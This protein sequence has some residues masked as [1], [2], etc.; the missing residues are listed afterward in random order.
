MAQPSRFYGYVRVSRVQGREGDTFISPAVQEERIRAWARGRGVE[1]VEVVHELDRSG[2]DDTRPGF[3]R[4][5]AAVEDG[6]ADGIVVAKLDRFARSLLDALLAV[7][8][9]MQGGGHLASVAEGFDTSTTMGRA[10]VAMM[11]IWAEVELERI[12]E[13]WD[14]AKG[15]A[16][17]RGVHIS[18]HVPCGYSRDPQTRRLVAIPDAVPV[19]RELF[20]RRAAGERWVEL[21]DFMRASGLRTNTG[22][23]RWTHAA[24]RSLITNRVYLGEARHGEHVKAGAH[25]AM[26]TQAQFDAAQGEKAAPQ[27]VSSGYELSGLV[28]CAGC[29]NRSRGSLTTSH[30]K[31]KRSYT[32]RRYHAAG[33]CPATGN[34]TAE[35]LEAHV[36][37]AVHERLLASGVGLASG[38][39]VAA[40]VLAAQADVDRAKLALGLLVDRLDQLV[41]SL[42][43]DGAGAMLD[44]HRQR[45]DVAEDALTVARRQ[46]GP[47]RVDAAAFGRMTGA[48]RRRFYGELL[49]GVMVRSAKEHGLR[50]APLADRVRLLWR[51]L[52]HPPLAERT[53]G[54]RVVA[55]PW[56]EDHAGVV[57]PEHAA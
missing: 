48:E 32:C 52:P 15:R 24:L 6:E 5:V 1:L 51:G 30:G 16:V 8:R 43:A 37:E 9:L 39:M 50:G 13:N 47:G 12:R 19:I 42:G 3:Q 54:G 18:G 11:L 29:S 21:G 40:D 33:V 46:A 27:V 17:G 34:V 35:L 2:G 26:V 53:R 57:Q 7:R 23:D 10:V 28:Y 25:E 45:V 38:E 44:D 36:F 20:E 41:G 56:P 14:V 22:S 55:W 4:I 49:D 31:R